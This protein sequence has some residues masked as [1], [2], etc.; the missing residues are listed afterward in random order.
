[1]LLSIFR[2][3]STSGVIQSIN[4]SLTVEESTK[5]KV[6]SFTVAFFRKAPSMFK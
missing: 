5:F 3:L 6:I 4:N 2:N 1:M